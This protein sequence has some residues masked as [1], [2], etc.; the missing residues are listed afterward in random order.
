M[1]SEDIELRRLSDPI[2]RYLLLIVLGTLV[3]GAAGFAAARVVPTEYTATSSLLVSPISN[4]AAANLGADVL[5]VDMA[6]EVELT[7]SLAVAT[8]AQESLGGPLTPSEIL[9]DVEAKV[10]K[11]SRVIEVT[12]TAETRTDAQAGAQAI[13]DGY[14]T[15]RSELAAGQR[16]RAKDRVE[17]RIEELKFELANVSATRAEP[18]LSP[19]ADLTAAVEEQT[20]LGELAVNQK[21]LADINGVATD[22]VTVIDPANRPSSPSSL[23]LIPLVVSGAALGLAA[24]LALAFLVGGSPASSLSNERLRT[25]ADARVAAS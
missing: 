11:D 18:N 17:L 10:V 13:A 5:S 19:A 21:Q 16:D 24:S 2:R 22:T 25:E 12:Y 6:T 9:A 20:I 23:G 14:V 3:G 7:T 1:S 4:E 8:I 15:F